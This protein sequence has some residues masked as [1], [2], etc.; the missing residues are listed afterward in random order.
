MSNQEWLLKRNCSLS[1]RQAGIAYAAQCMVS[2]SV[3][4]MCTLHGAWQVFI[5][6][7]LEMLALGAA[8]LVYAR[9]ATDNEHVALM[10]GSLLVERTLAG[11][12]EV[13]RLDPHW[14][15]ILP[16]KRYQDLI[17]LESH[18][19]RVEIGRFV[20]ADK[21]KQIARELQNQLHYS[22]AA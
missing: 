3:A 1:P 4:T 2:F 8:Y 16:P 14:T 6:S 12:Q 20:T 7:V 10:D 19:K 11:K 18:G 17:R 13:I 21:R 15:R 5:F 22:M 9:H